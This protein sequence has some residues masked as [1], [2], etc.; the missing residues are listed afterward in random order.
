MDLS[1]ENIQLTYLSGY[2]RSNIDK[3][4]NF[5]KSNE[6]AENVQKR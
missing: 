6:F 4:L 3:L 1:D 5:A 2:K